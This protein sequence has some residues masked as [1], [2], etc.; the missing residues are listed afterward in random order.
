MKR[1][2]LPL[3]AAITFPSL[4]GDLGPADFETLEANKYEIT[5]KDDRSQDFGQ[6]R[7]GF[8]NKIGKCTVKFINGRLTVN[9]S[10]GITPQQV[11][12]FDT[13]NANDYVDS[14]QIVYKDSQGI[15]TSATFH[16]FDRVKRWHRFM[17]EFLYFI[18]QD[19]EQ[20]K[21]NYF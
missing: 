13:F 9:D 4:A 17:K 18:N 2:L 12:F 21:P 16:T 10:K 5:E 20:V 15:I 1:F 19:N 7:C 14:L 8:R 6:M 11:L 3:L